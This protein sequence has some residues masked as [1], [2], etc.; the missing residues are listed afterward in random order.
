MAGY[1]CSAAYSCASPFCVCGIQRLDGE[2]LVLMCQCCA[3]RVGSSGIERL[4][5]EWLA[6]MFAAATDVCLECLCSWNR[7]FR[8]RMACFDDFNVFCCHSCVPRVGASGIER[9]DGEWLV[10]MALQSMKDSRFLTLAR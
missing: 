6:L 7:A 1:V 10:L 4:D 5:G 8:W 3:S 2:C 9:P